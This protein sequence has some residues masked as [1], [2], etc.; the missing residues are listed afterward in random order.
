[1]RILC[2]LP[3]ITLCLGSCVN[4]ARPTQSS[5]SPEELDS[6]NQYCRQ[7]NDN[8]CCADSV[9]YVRTGGTIYDGCDDRPSNCDDLSNVSPNLKKISSSVPTRVNLTLG[10]TMWTDFLRVHE[11][12]Q[13]GFVR[14]AKSDKRAS[15]IG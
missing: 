12:L 9:S 11:L 4:I 3:L 5:F 2:L 6:D 7:Y 1:M 15:T 13:F 8:S 14:W 10:Q